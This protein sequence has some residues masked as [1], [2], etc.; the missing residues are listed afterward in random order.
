[1]VR[2]F[3]LRAKKVFITVPQT[4]DI[5]DGIDVILERIKDKIGSNLE[6]AIV[7]AES[8]KDGNPHIHAVIC[9]QQTPELKGPDC[10]D[11]VCGK[12]GNYKAVRNLKKSIQYL[13]KDTPPNFVAYNIDIPEI[14]K[15][16]EGKL[17]LCVRLLDAG[18]DL[19][20][21]REQFPELFFMHRRKVD[22]Y[23][24]YRDS[25]APTEFPWS[26]VSARLSVCTLP[27]ASWLVNNIRKDRTIRTPQ[28]YLH[29][30]PGIGKTR[31]WTRLTRYLRVYELPMSEDFNDGYVD[32]FDLVVVEEF[33]GQRPVSFMNSFLDGQPMRLKIKGGQYY[34]KKN[35]P[36]LIVSNYSPQQ[37]YKNI[38]PI[39]CD[40]FTSRLTVI[41][42]NKLE[43]DEI[44]SIITCYD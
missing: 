22:S 43:L 37:V 17:R 3:R 18:G 1:M 30:P 28:L 42:T 23:M 26:S 34:K 21:V 41:D 6:Y 10:L 9:F 36:V 33:M 7:C 39:L 25:L 38:T 4:G 13:I 20:K 14:L 24:E 29:G 35:V 5:Q 8:H 19:E 40:A 2:Q 27:I 44:D 32:N 11:W 16:K 31:L 15:E 12:H